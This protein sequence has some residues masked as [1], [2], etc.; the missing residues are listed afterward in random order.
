MKVEKKQHLKSSGMPTEILDKN[1]LQL[2]NLLILNDL[3]TA[4]VS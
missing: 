1:L 4:V 2:L 3:I